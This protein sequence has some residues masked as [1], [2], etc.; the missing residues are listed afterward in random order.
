MA[1]PNNR[2]NT[3]APLLAIEDT[4][5]LLRDEMRPIRFALEYSKAELELR[6]WGIRSTII[7]FGSA[8]IPSPE[9]A[10]AAVAAAQT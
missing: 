2:T 3:R 10:E 6:D 4:Q 1:D 9:T 7:V 5:F 8:R